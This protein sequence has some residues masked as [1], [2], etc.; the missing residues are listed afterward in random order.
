MASD[1]I[2]ILASKN[3][4]LIVQ[5]GFITLDIAGFIFEKKTIE[6]ATRNMLHRLRAFLLKTQSVLKEN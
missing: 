1:I 3:H 5:T 4:E 2:G 6:C